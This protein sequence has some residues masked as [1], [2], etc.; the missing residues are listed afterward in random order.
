[1]DLTI[2]VFSHALPH[3]LSLSF[4]LSP[5]L[6]PN[7]NTI[8]DLWNCHTISTL[9]KEMHNCT[10]CNLK[11]MINTKIKTVLQEIRF[12]NMSRLS[13][14]NDSRRNESNARLIMQLLQKIRS[15]EARFKSNSSVV[16]SNWQPFT[17]VSFRIQKHQNIDVCYQ[18]Q[19]NETIE[20]KFRNV[21]SRN[22]SSIRQN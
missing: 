10:V 8:M 13:I 9:L 19:R 7:V 12:V 22:L 2:H 15:Q 6:S 1:M 20:L 3:Y 14:V 11:L 16:Y 5:S 17:I 4:P 18:I 21:F